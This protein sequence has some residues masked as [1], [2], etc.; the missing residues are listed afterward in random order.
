VTDPFTDALDLL[1]ERLGGA[2]LAANDE[3]F[4]PKESLVRAAPAVFR[5]HEYTDRGKWMDG[6]ETRRRREPG[7]D[8]CILRLGLPGILHG[9]D[10]DTAF[11]TGNY[12]EACAIEACELSGYP[13]VSVLTSP[14]VTWR[15]ILPRSA[16]GGDSHNLL[17]IGDRGRYTHLRLNIYPD[18]G[19]ARLRAYGRVVPDPVR[20]ASLRAD[21]DLAAAENGGFVVSCSD[22]FYGSRNNLIMP[23]LPRIM[24]E[25][26]ETKRRR[27]P[28]HD[29]AV[30]RL[31]FRGAIHRVE[32]DTMHFKG[33][34]PDSCTLEACDSPEDEASPGPGSDWR[35]VLPSTK[36]QPNT[37]HVFAGEIVDREAASHVRLNIYPD[38]GVAR[39]RVHGAIVE[40]D[41]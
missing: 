8:W 39:L 1:S 30:V 40:A 18:G 10:V 29:W 25:G 17:P 32:V 27:G 7:F 24:A 11:F 31:G 36:L 9:V 35:T 6:W 13:D 12:P 38:G 22:M 4:A 16:L 20:I 19:V 2:A 5:E 14:D 15:E 28:G 23:G 3:F 37:R 34:A 21:L 33:N 41:R 26:W